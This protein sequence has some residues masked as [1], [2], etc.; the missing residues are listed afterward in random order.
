LRADVIN[1][2]N[3]APAHLPRHAPVEGRRVDDHGNCRPFLVG[4]ANQF[5]I[6]PKNLRKMTKN[7]S[8]ADNRKVFS[9][10]NNL[11]SGS[12]HALPARPKKF[13]ARVGTGD[14]PVQ[15]GR[16]RRGGRIRPPSGVQLRRPPP[17][18]FHQ[19]RAIHFARSFTGGDQD[20]HGAI[21][22][23]SVLAT[24]K[25]SLVVKRV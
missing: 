3:A 1:D 13:N 7:L 19:L 22:N 17:Q 15:F 6:K 8:D 21:V 4:R 25:Q 23:A 10:D 12:K 11:A 2:G 5:P 16:L 14:S 20:L 18:S 9:V 24:L